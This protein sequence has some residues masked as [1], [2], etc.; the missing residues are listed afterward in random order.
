MKAL[1]NANT[2]DFKNYRESQYIIYDEEIVE[3]GSMKDFIGADEIYDC[4]GNIVMPGLVNGHTH[5]YSTLARGMNLPFNPKRFKDILNQLWWKL[6]SKLDKKAVYYSAL[7]SGCECIKSGVTTVIDHHASGMDIMGTLNELKKG[8]CDVMGLRGIF[9]F[10]TSD[11]FDVDQCIKEN[12]T[13]IKKRNANFAGLFGMHASMSLSNSTLKKIS[14][15]IGDYPIHIHSAESIEDEEDCRRQYG[16]SVIERFNDYNLLNENSILAHCVHIDEIE[17]E[18]IAKSGT[19]VALNPTSNMNNAV[20]LPNFELLRRKGI[21]CIVGNDGLGNNLTRDYM[22]LVFSMKNRLQ[23][24][25]AFSIN[26][27]VEVIN[28]GYDYAGKTLGIKLGSIEK[29][30]KADFIT[31]PYIPPTPIDNKNALGHIFFGV[32][33]NFHPRDLWCNGKILMK[34]YKVC[35][36]IYSI[37]KKAQQ[38]ASELWKRV[39]SENVINLRSD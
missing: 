30:Y 38:E 34:D 39:T 4:S 14:N 16:K 33:D 31:L 15:I 19:V 20:G 12:L 37:Y 24:P 10:E 3:V 32:F 28:N 27:L 23:S 2:F 17:A 29:G 1:I 8:I 13:F 35:E 25:T 5:I 21:K 7:V 18:I 9:C 11:R 36:D 22:N 26:D 6:D